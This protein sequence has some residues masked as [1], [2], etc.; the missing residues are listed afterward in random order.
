[1]GFIT[2][3]DYES[4]NL[5]VLF[6]VLDEIGGFNSGDWYNQIKYKC[7]CNNNDKSFHSK[8]EL[9]KM[10]LNNFNTHHIKVIYENN[11]KGE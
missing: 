4:N 5:L 11:T 1:M 10:I 6:R 3:D 8:D 9:K 2:L 7:E